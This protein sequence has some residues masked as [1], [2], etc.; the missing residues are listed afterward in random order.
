MID[1]S[2]PVDVHARLSEEPHR[3][4]I[5][6]RMIARLSRNHKNRRMQQIHKLPCRLRLQN[7]RVPPFII[8]RRRNGLHPQRRVSGFG[9]W[10]VRER[11][12]GDPEWSF[13]EPL[14]DAV[15]ERR[16]GRFDGYDCADELGPRVR[17]QP[18]RGAALGVR[19]EDGGADAVEEG[20]AGGFHAALLDVKVGEVLD[21]AGEVD[22]EDG[23]ACAA[24][25]GPLR[26][27]VGLGPIFEI[28][29]GG[30]WEHSRQRLTFFPLCLE[31]GLFHVELSGNGWN[32]PAAPD[33]SPWERNLLLR[34]HNRGPVS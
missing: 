13:D 28:G 3:A 33:K 26:V 23:V 6:G 25:T 1:Q 27:E 11:Q 4:L 29:R 17:D 15:G 10:V 21:R 8:A 5:I 20:G 18:A 2:N 14:L 19:D 31:A 22:V 9:R 34:R 24:G 7:P 30:P 12:V 32:N 16:T